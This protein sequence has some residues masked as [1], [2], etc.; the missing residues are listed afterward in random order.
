MS[1]AQQHRVIGDQR[2]HGHACGGTTEETYV[3][4]HSNA[5]AR[6]GRQNPLRLADARSRT[7]A[8]LAAAGMLATVALGL[9]STAQAEVNAVPDPSFEAGTSAWFVTTGAKLARVTPGYSGNF[10]ARVTNS[11]TKSLT[12]ALNDKVNTVAK[13][14]KGQR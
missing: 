11:S 9:G 8:G 4:R 7:I 12:V 1:Q 10:A 14:V 2:L 13:T 5:P 3:S 6:H